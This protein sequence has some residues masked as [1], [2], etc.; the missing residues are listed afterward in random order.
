MK[1]LP[2]CKGIKHL[3]IPHGN[4]SVEEN[5]IL[6]NRTIQ[7]VCNRLN[8]KG[9]DYYLV[10]A[11]AAFIGTNTPLF[12]YHGDID[13]MIAEKDIDKVREAI[14]GTEYEFSDNRFNNKKRLEEGVGQ[15]Q[16]E[17]E[18]IANHKS[19]EFHLGFFLFRREQDNVL[20]VREYFMQENENGQKVPMILERSYPKELTSLEYTQDEIEY[21]GTRFRISTPESIFTKKICTLTEKDKLDVEVLKDKVDQRRIAEMNKYEQTL[22]IVKPE[23]IQQINKSMLESAIDATEQRTKTSDIEQQRKSIDNIKKARIEEQVLDL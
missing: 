4:I 19:N 11:L 15:T 23:K 14:Q 6:I 12:R 22:K 8:E 9:V 1:S 17:H 13:F 3:I 2:K 20:T 10:G 21:V 5:H 18:V 7:T 16:G